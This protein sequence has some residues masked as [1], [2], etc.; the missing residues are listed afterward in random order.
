[1]L[2]LLLVVVSSCV[3][4][5]PLEGVDVWFV[6]DANGLVELPLKVLKFVVL[7]LELSIVVV[8]RDVSNELKADLGVGMKL[9]KTSPC[10][11]FRSSIGL[12]FDSV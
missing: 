6:A 1:M 8:R 12:Y 7:A 11:V 10:L 4:K 9:L 2:K 5:S 3:L